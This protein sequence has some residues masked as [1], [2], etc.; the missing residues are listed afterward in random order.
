MPHVVGYHFTNVPS[1]KPYRMSSGMFREFHRQQVRDGR[2]HFAGGWGFA[3]QGL[4]DVAENLGDYG[5]KVGNDAK[6]AADQLAAEM[7]AWAK[8]NAPWEDDGAETGVHARDALQAGVV[9]NSESS[10]TIFLGHGPTI[11]YGIWLEVR[12]GGK[13]AIILPTIYQ[14]APH[15]GDRI[16][17]MT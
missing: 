5:I 17:T 11:F 3:W 8:D 9:W 15:L 7:L 14:F 2:G 12:W 6:K 1:A 16:R 4:S 13:F 10:F